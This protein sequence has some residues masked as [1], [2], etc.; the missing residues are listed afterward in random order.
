[1]VTITAS[2]ETGLNPISKVD[3]VPFD[4]VS[5][6]ATVAELTALA[7]ANAALAVLRA[8]VSVPAPP[9]LAARNA[10]LAVVNALLEKS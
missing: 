1:M 8:Y 10:A 4:V 5:N 3:T 2:S 6:T 9:V 7:L